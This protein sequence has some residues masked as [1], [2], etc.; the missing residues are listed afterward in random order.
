[1]KHPTVKIAL[2]AIAAFALG[3]HAEIPVA[4]AATSDDLMAQVQALQT[5]VAA[6]ERSAPPPRAAG[7]PDPVAVLQSQMAAITQVLTVSNSG[8]V[9]RTPGSISIQAD[10]ALDIQAKGTM[11]VSA[12]V[13]RLNGGNKPVAHANGTSATV[14]V[15]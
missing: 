13:L 11:N 4:Q 1:M 5:K 3:R 10:A 6:L 9:L 14:Q 12:P 15:P 2:V 7:A 8:L